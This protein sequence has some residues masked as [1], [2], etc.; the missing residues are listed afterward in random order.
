MSGN[1]S[2]V[3]NITDI[4]SKFNVQKNRIKVPQ[5]LYDLETEKCV[6]SGIIQASE[7]KNERHFAD[8][9]FS[10]LESTDFYDNRNEIIYRM[11][12]FLNRNEQPI[13]I[14][15]IRLSLMQHK[16]K[17]KDINFFEMIGGNEYLW[18]VYKQL[19]I[20]ENI[21]THVKILIELSCTRSFYVQQTMTTE[22]LNRYCIPI[23]EY[24]QQMDDYIEKTK[25][26]LLSVSGKEKEYK[27]SA[28]LSDLEKN[29]DER[30]KRYQEKIKG[31]L[32]EED[33]NIV[34]LKCG[35]NY[36]DGMSN[37]IKPELYVLMADT[38]IGKTAQMISIVAGLCKHNKNIN[39]L[40]FTPNEVV[41]ETATMRLVSVITEICSNYGV[42][43]DDMETGNLDQQDIE[44][45]SKA[46]EVLN[47]KN[48]E[49]VD[50]I[51]D[52][53]EI[54]N[55]IKDRDKKLFGN[56]DVVFIDYLQNVEDST[57]KG[58]NPF[59]KY[60]EIT[61]K[62]DKTKNNLD[63]KIAMFILTQENNNK[64]SRRDKTPIKTDAEYA[65]KAV[66]LAQYMIALAPK[67]LDE[68]E[69][70]ES[71]DENVSPETVEI[72]AYILKNK[73][74]HCRRTPIDLTIT[75][76]GNVVETKYL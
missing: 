57:F 47:G 27:L 45:I 48:V 54:S 43:K 31:G 67:Q 66:K 52:V 9:V 73:T 62:L 32:S 75:K 1:T 60:T 26:R 30:I 28:L 34:G 17:Y 33:A 14:K 3:V 38:N 2:N 19:T 46:M 53:N 8:W 37:G 16:H 36:L 24:I 63:S 6:L 21:K 40:W 29:F 72:Q 55:I 39:I 74:K 12:L 4:S 11:M 70:L 59:E 15:T 58:Y 20:P 42:T 10:K 22:N 18:D 61:Q 25:L 50:N 7:N 13:D 76:T 23:D 41:Q 44:S 51:S 35:I 68:D 71:N 64:A 49:I 56:L 65:S 5:T 69:D